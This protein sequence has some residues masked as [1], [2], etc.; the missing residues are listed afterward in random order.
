MLNHEIST[1]IRKVLDFRV[2][3]IC[4]DVL[5]MKMTLLMEL[6][7]LQNQSGVYFVVTI[8]SVLQCN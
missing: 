5:A 8:V 6:T 3:S 7:Q 4:L 1:N 2:P